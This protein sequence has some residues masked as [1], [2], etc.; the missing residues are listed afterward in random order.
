MQIRHDI[1]L[2][3]PFLIPLLAALLCAGLKDDFGKQR[4]LSIVTATLVLG[5][6]G[7]IFYLTAAK[8][9]ILVLPI[10]SWVP[11]VGIVWVAD[12][13]SGL[14]LF[15][16]ALIFLMTFV[17]SPLGVDSAEKRYFIPLLH[18]LMVGINGAFLTGDLFNLFVFF[19]VLLVASFVLISQGEPLL[20]VKK[21]LPY[22]IMNLVASATFLLAVGIMYAV[23][24]TVT[25]A[26][27]GQMISNGPMS[28]SFWLAASLI[29]V[30]FCT[31]AGLVPWHYWLPDSYPQSSIPVNALFAG[32]LTKVGIYALY[33]FVPLL[34]RAGPSP[35]NDSLLVIAALTMT[36][37]VIG[38]L[39][40]SQ[41]REILSFHIISQVGY[42]VFG[43][44]LGT[45]LAMAA[46]LFYILHH[47]VVKSA[48]FMAVGI[49][50]LRAGSG[51][52]GVAQGVLRLDP[53]AAGIFLVLAMALAGLPPLSGFWAKLFLIAAGFES[54]AWITTAVA[55]VVGLLT[56]ASMLKIWNASY[57]GNAAESI[58]K[59]VP[60]VHR[61]HGAALSLAA[62]SLATGLLAIPL[63]KVFGQH[64]SHLITGDSYISAVMELNRTDL[65]GGAP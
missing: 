47:I 37:G 65:K 62:L 10:G 16:A 13:L 63:F 33:R 12:A 5:V 52:L 19:E 14:F 32:L 1:L 27:L 64:A 25:L 35:L 29:V 45:K 2:I 23:T 40:R 53:A 48:L 41:L 34:N 8:E 22:V 56:L 3:M 26:E 17:I 39:G 6:S 44:G 11:G 15:L 4:V 9:L 31:K 43:L 28:G 61:L 60:K 57:W 38:A 49:V 46:G 7:F 59:S 58:W 30:V 51:K 20:R 36:I 18:L 21:A 55:I 50:E 54:E 42:M 24:G